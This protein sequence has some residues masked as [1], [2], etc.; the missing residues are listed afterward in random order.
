MIK[1]TALRQHLI[2]AVPQL[3][4]GPERLL[5]FIERGA[6]RFARGQHLSHQYRVP[7]KIVVTDYAGEIDAVV[8]PLLQWLSHYQPDL[9]DEEAV[10]IDAELLASGR[11]DLSL[12]VTLTERV[13]ATVDCAEGRIQAEHRMPEYPIDA[14]P[15]T[16][17]QL[18]TKAPSDDYQL[19]S[20]WDSPSG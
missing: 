16:H 6:I 20:E 2:T 18:H 12:E 8:I 7:A 9:D 10:R 4:Q 11:W 1:L 17:W 15:A 14:C 13:V 5:T 19:T 3:R